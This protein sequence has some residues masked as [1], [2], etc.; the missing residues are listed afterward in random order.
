M[1][2]KMILQEHAVK[3]MK[4]KPNIGQT[5]I[6]VIILPLT[7]FPV[8]AGPKRISRLIRTNRSCHP[9]CWDRCR[10]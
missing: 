2:P 10:S 4:K 9:A 3:Y 6:L 1:K 5:I 8:S 7:A